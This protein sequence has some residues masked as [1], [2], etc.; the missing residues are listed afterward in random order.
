MS[1]GT[2]RLGCAPK[3]KNFFDQGYVALAIDLYRGK[4]AFPAPKKLRHFRKA[5]P[6]TELSGT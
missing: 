4:V 3:P 1:G 2:R 6:G 5:S